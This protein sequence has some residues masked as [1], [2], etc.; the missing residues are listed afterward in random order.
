[1]RL[2]LRLKTF[3]VQAS[4][5][6]V[7]YDRQNI[8]ILQ[9]TGMEWSSSIPIW[10]ETSLPDTGHPSRGADPEDLVSHP[11]EVALASGVRPWQ[12]SD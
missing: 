4:L 8:F 3:I 1:M 7:T 12:L 9:T 11:D 2:R 5:A 10:P 6:I